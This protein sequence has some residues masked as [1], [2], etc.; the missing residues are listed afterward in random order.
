MILPAEYEIRMLVDGGSV[1]S[2]LSR[3]QVIGLSD[4]WYRSGVTD[5]PVL[6]SGF[7]AD[8]SAARR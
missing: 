5:P 7:A 6:C 8:S 3:P 2:Y 4:L 1:S